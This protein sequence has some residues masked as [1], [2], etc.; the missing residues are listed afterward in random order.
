MMLFPAPF[1]PVGGGPAL[2]RR[3]CR[4]RLDRCRFGSR[5]RF[6]A[7][8]G[9][10]GAERAQELVGFALAG[11]DGGEHLEMV[12]AIGDDRGELIAQDRLGTFGSRSAMTAAAR[13]GSTAARAARMLGRH[14][15]RFRV[16]GEHAC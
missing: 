1:S 15:E 13:C 5:G 14:E 16:D 11:R 7:A 6:C 2:C 3:R 4:R 10:R 9:D 12:V 8:E